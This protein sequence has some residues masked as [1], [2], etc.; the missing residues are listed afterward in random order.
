ME[1]SNTRNIDLWGYLY[2]LV[3]MQAY[4]FNYMTS[5]ENYFAF[6]LTEVIKY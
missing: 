6:E 3:I 5:C 1:Y 2:H 4:Q